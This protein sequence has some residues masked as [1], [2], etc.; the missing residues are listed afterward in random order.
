[1]D[2]EDAVV[3]QEQHRQRRRSP[4]RDDRARRRRPARRPRRARPRPRASPRPACARP[5]GS[6]LERVGQRHGRG[7]ELAHPLR[8]VLLERADDGRVEHRPRLEAELD[9]ARADPCDEL[10]PPARGGRAAGR[11]VPYLSRPVTPRPRRARAC[12]AGR[13]RPGRRARRRRRRRRP[14]RHVAASSTARSSSSAV[15][16]LV[17]DG[18]PRQDERARRRRGA[19]RRRSRTSIELP[20][21]SVTARRIAGW[22]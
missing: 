17:R 22:L 3:A 19:G 11:V 9:R 12:A 15:E 21:A 6:A 20:P 10:G 2:G 7:D 13:R 18:E 5:T 4:R 8:P 1:M 16:R 14:A